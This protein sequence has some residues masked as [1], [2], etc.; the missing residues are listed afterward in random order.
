MIG[1]NTPQTEM[2]LQEVMDAHP[3]QLV[4]IAYERA[5][6]ACER[7]ASSQASEI[8]AVLRETLRAE[9]GEKTPA[10]AVEYQYC[11]DNISI[12]DYGAAL[13][14]LQELKQAWTRRT[15]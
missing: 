5:I 8:I 9:M 2:T 7:K 6:R 11:L 1:N 15:A 3:N 13:H 14:S 4:L 12:G 10:L